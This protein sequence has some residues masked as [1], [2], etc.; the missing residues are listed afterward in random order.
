[1]GKTETDLHLFRIW[2]KAGKT[3]NNRIIDD[4]KRYGL[5]A[6]NFSV[7]ELLYNK[8][9]QHVQPM[10][11]KLMIPSGSITYVVN[12][13]EEKGLVRKVQD[14][15]NRRYW[16]VSL[17]QEGEGLFDEIF[18]Q[19]VETI[20]AILDPLTEEQKEELGKLLKI[21]GLNAY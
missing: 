1:M 6:D 20:Q 14:E 17:T 10:C 9:P 21:L 5:A 7:L 18:P 8:G 11:D 3:I 4:L 15:D 12:K 19:H 16:K 13:L 2:L